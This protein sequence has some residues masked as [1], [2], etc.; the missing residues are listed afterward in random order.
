MSSTE[1]VYKFMNNTIGDLLF[2]EDNMLLQ[3][4]GDHKYKPSQ[5]VNFTKLNM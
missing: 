2:F 3:D 1:D 5:Q 4:P